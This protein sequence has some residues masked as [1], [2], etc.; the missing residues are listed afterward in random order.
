[1]MLVGSLCSL[2]AACNR[3]APEP[4]S[5]HF[6]SAKLRLTIVR[7]ATDLFLQ[8][9]NLTLKV[10]GE[11]GCSS[12]TDLFPD[13]GHSGRRNVYL[14]GKGMIYVVGQF[15]ARVIDP[16]DCRA[17]LSEFR[18]LDRQVV[19]LGSFDQNQDKRWGYFSAAE[20][21]ELPFEKR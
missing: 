20:R 14:A 21:P 19:F 8:R 2:G 12:S 10:Q 18:H 9:F 4:A 1:M 16:Q 17:T 7:T 11:T 6:P 5:A 3:S 15:D 13:T